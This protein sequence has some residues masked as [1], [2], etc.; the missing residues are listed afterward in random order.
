MEDTTNGPSRAPRRTGLLVAL[1]GIVGLLAGGLV[2][3][4]GAAPVVSVVVGTV[5]AV[6]VVVLG[7]LRGFV[8]YRR[9][10]R[11]LRPVNPTVTPA[12]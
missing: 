12:R 8:T 1:A 4:L 10:I 3:A 2:S 11:S 6:A 9:A 7:M 5:V